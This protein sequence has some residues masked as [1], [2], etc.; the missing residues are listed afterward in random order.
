MKGGIQRTL[1]DL[2][3][4]AGYLMDSFGNGPAVV[5]AEGE[6]SED[7]EVQRAL[8]EI[9]TLVSHQLPLSFYT[10]DSIPPVEAQGG[11]N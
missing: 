8:R 4:F 6:C 5:G 2:Q 10:D 3:D 1:L 11:R 7:Q 9:D